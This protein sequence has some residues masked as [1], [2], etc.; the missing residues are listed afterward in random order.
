MNIMK[1]NNK[2]DEFLNFFKLKQDLEKKVELKKASQNER[3]LT[4]QEFMK[5]KQDIFVEL[6]DILQKLQS[7]MNEGIPKEEASF[8]IST[9]KDKKDEDINFLLEESKNIY[10]NDVK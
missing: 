3:T 5:F 7:W 1:K 9:I 2:T 8:I 4:P 6:R 10:T